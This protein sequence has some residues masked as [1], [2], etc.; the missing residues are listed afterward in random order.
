M[1]LE[2]M[3]VCNCHE[4]LRGPE[5]ALEIVFACQALQL[6][7]LAAII[8]L[9]SMAGSD[10]AITA[11]RVQTHSPPHG[12]PRPRFLWLISLMLQGRSFM[13]LRFEFVQWP[14]VVCPNHAIRNAQMGVV[15]H[16]ATWLHAGW[17][18]PAS[19]PFV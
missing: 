19:E 7:H 12:S 4:A 2:E 6:H 1:L 10:Q 15:M 8:P 9:R 17:S 13:P 18:K 11:S 5:H 16:E 3:L 14:S